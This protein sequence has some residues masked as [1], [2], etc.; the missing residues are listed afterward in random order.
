MS[1]PTP[2]R[3]QMQPS[4][5]I[6]ARAG[7]WSA[8][9]WKTAIVGWLAFVVLAFMIGGNVGTKQLTQE[10][11][12]VRRLRHRLQARPRRLPAGRQRGRPGLQQGEGRSIHLSSA[13]SSTTPSNSS[14]RRRACTTSRTRTPRATRTASRR[15][16]TSRWS[17]FDIPG[18]P[19]A[20]TETKRVMDATVAS[21]EKLDAAHDD[22]LVEQFGD[23]SSEEDFQKIFQA[24]LAKAGH[25]LAAADAGHPAR[26][27]RHAAGRRH[28]AAARGERRPG[29]VRPHRP[30]SARSSRSR[31]PSSTS[32]C[33]SVLPWASTTRCST[34]DG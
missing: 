8:R 10:E 29:D 9:H 23:G 27:V 22:F 33:S 21:T 31:S 11:A 1:I 5:N 24:D 18:D 17:S 13:P 34:C 32:S 6:A 12:G 14:R 20:D 15:T 25:A 4:R 2:R 3:Q 16:S 28:P 7:R 19:V 26:H 30:A